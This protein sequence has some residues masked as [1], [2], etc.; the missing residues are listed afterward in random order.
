MRKMELDFLRTR[1]PIPAAAWL[2]LLAGIVLA[3]LAGTRYLRV[4]DEL[5]RETALAAKVAPKTATHKKTA[6]P[7]RSGVTEGDLL[8]VSWGDLFAR[9]EA[10]RPAD[11]AFLALSA[12]GRK[13]AVTL[14]AE[15]RNATDMINYLERLRQEGGFRSV[16][17]AGHTV[18]QAEDGRE[19]LHFLAR[20]NW[21]Q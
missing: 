18:M 17:L 9:L 1:P 15:A 3:S 16:S 2:L 19:S 10:T 6:P 8:A 21:G 5:A 13:G 14:T 12:D 4:S 11:I 20:L 7:A